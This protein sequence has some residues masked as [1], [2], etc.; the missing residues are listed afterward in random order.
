MTQKRITSI[1]ILLCMLVSMFAMPTA[2]AATVDTADTSANAD[3]A[4]TSANADVAET[5]ANSYGLASSVQGGQ[6]LQ[7]WNWSYNNIKN[8]LDKIAD[9]GFTAIQ[10][11]PIQPIKETT[12]ESWNTINN[13]SWVVYQ[14]VAFNIE[15]N[16]MNAQGTK[17][18]FKSLCT[19]AHKYGIK[20][21]VDTIF[22]HMANDMSGNTIHPWIP[23]EIK[24][25]S[26]CWHDITKNTYNFDDRYEVTQYC[27]TGL[28]DLNTS[29]SIVQKHCINF[30]KEAIDAGADGFRFDAI[31]H[32]E[33]PDDYYTYASDFWPNVL[34]AA[35]S[36]AQST[37]NLT[38]YYYGELIGNP[39][40]GL[41]VNA[42]T[43]YMSVSDPGSS[44]SIRDGVCNGDASKAA[45]GGI[46]CGAVPSKTVQWTESHDNHKDNG[47]NMVS[48]HNI[49]KVWAIVGSKAEV[50]GM[51]LARPENMDTTMMGDAD[52]TSWTY[53]EVKAVNRFK[54]HFEGQS[55]YLS[56]YYNLAC[57]ER[58]NSG[59]IIVNTGGTYYNGMSAP[60]HTMMD[61]T[62]KDAITGNTF[63]VSGGMISGDIGNTGIAVVYNASNTGIFTPGKVTG[64]SLPGSFNDWDS[65]ANV[66]M[67]ET[68]ST[69]STTISLAKGTYTFKIRGGDVWFSNTGSI[70]DTTDWNGASNPWEMSST[71][72]ADCTLVA[73]GGRYK[74]TY[75]APNRKLDVKKLS[76]STT[77]SSSF[78]LK[79]DF[80]SWGTD[81]RMT[82]VDGANSVTTTV[83]LD[84]GTYGFK[85]NNN[86][87]GIW[88]GNWGTIVDTT[89]ATS[90]TGWEMDPS[91]DVSN[92]TLEATKS[93]KYTF[94][95]NL[96]TQML[97]VTNVST[98][99]ATFKDWDGTVLKTQSVNAGVAPTA[100][101]NPTRTGYTFTG[102]SPAV[103]A[104]TT[105][106]TFTA[107]YKINSYAVSV[108]SS[109]TAGG[110]TKASASTVNY[111]STVTLTA[112][113]NS[114]DNYSFT[115]WQISGSYTI[116]SGSL[117]STS[118]TIAPTSAITAVANYTQAATYTVSASASTGG[119][120][121][122]SHASV[123][124]GNSV[125]FSAT[126]SKGYSFSNWTVSGSYTAVS[127]STSSATFTI[128]PSGNITVKANFA[129]NQSTVKF[130]ASTGG[131]VTNT[132]AAII[133]YPN[134]RS[135]TATASTGY[136][137]SS[138]IISGGTLGTDY[139]IT[140]GSTS[141]TSIS[142]RPITSGKTIT[143]TASFTGI[144]ATVKF[145]A[146]TGGT[147]TNSG[148]NSVTYPSTK[149][150]VASVSTG[151]TFSGWT[152]S[153]GTQ[154]TDYKITAGGGTNTSITIQ[155]LTEGKTITATASF[156]LKSYIVTFL[157]YDGSVLSSQS[158]KHGSAATAPADPTRT[159]YVFTGWDT[160]F[161]NVTSAMTVTA[162][163]TDD[164]VFLLGD[165]NGW[166]T[167][168]GAM[169]T[170]SGNVVSK[171][172]TLDA[173]TYEFKLLHKD[174]W[175]GNDGTIPDTTDWNGASNPWDMY[176]NSGNCKLEATGGT[177]T[178]KYNKSTMKLEVVHTAP[179]YT[180]TFKNY[181]GVTLKTETVQRGND[182]TAP[183]NPTRTATAQ[184]TYTFTG[185][186][187]EFTNI[188]SDLIVTAQFSSKLRQYTVTFANYD[189]TTIKTQK[190]NYGSAATAPTTTPTRPATAQYT[191]TFKA[192]DKAFN[193]ITGDTTITATYNQTVNKYTV[194]FVNYDGSLLKS[195]SVAYGSAATAPTTTPTKPSD[196]QYSYTF[197]G[198]DKSFSNITGDLTVTAVYTSSGVSYTVTFKNWNGSVI[199]TQSVTYGGSAKAPAT[200]PT[201]ES[202]GQY[203]Y[204]F[205]G[206]DK[207]L[208]NIT[209]DTVITAQYTTSLVEYYVVFLDFYGDV[210]SEQMVPYGHD[211]VAPEDP[212]TIEE[213]GYIYV[214][215]GWDTDFTNIQSDTPVF[216]LYEEQE[217]VVTYTVT[218][219]N[220]DGTV[221]KR[222]TVEEG[223]SATAPGTPTRPS[224]AQYSYT[225]KA[226]DK[227]FS[228]VTSDLTVTA[229]YNQTLNK[230]EVTFK[231]YDGTVLKEQ[232]VEYGSAATAP[233]DPTRD[234]YIFSGWD[235]EFL[236]ITGNT[237]VTAQYKDATAYL[238]GDFNGWATDTAMTASAENVVSVTL[239]L[240]AGE[241]A[242]KILRA[243][244]WY[245]NYGVIED[246]TVTTSDVGWEMIDGADN[247]TL[248]TTGGKYTF[249]FNTLTRMLEVLH[250]PDSFTVTFVNYNGVTLDTQT[251]KRGE[252]ATAPADPTRAATAQ[253]TYTFK[254]WDTDFTN[255]QQNLTVK[256]LFS[257][258][259]NKYTVTFKNWDGT[260]LSTQQ[261][262]YGKSATAPA[263][264][265]RPADAQYTYTFKAWD[266]SFSSITGDTVVTA[267]YSQTVNKY[268]VK[269]VNYDGSVLKSESVAYGSAAT[270]P[271][272]PV[273]DGYD[274]TG[275]DKDF[276]EITGDLTVTAQFIDNRVYLMGDFNGWQ[277]NTVLTSAAGSVV[278]TTLELE[279]GEYAFKILY[280]DVWYSNTGV[281]P[282]TTDYNGTSNPWEMTSDTDNCTLN[283]TGGIY[284]F[285]FD[286]SANK[287]EVLFEKTTFTV[288]FV[289]YNGTVLSTQ[290]VNKGES[291][292]APA[293]P[294][295]L[296]T[297]QYTFT[298]AG[299]DKAFT[300]IQ[301]DTTITATYTQTVNKYTVTF[302]N[303]DGSVLSTQT[304][305]YGKGATAP[306]EP[307]RSGFVF[308]GWDKDF[309]EIT[310]NL[311]VTAQFA[312]DK[313][314]LLGDFNDW[315]RNTIL[316][317]VE[318]DVVS[319]T[320]ALEEGDYLFK[321]LHR[322]VWYGNG[323]TIADTTDY[324]G[325]SN[326]WE[327][328]SDADNCTLSATGGIYT[329]K[330]N[331][332]TH[333]LEVLFESNGYTVTF[334]NWD[335]TV[336]S[337]QVVK[338]GKS[339]TAPADPARESTAE[340]TY[341]FA[342][343]DT[344]FTNVQDNMTVTAT[345]TQAARKY[346]V[347]YVNYD[348]KTFYTEQVEYGKAA[349]GPASMPTRP[350]DNGKVYTFYGWDKDLDNITA[351]VKT[352]ALYTSAPVYYTVTFV[353][354]DGAVLKEES[355]QH[356]GSATAPEA[357]AVPAGYK[358]VWNPADF[359]YITSNLTV[360]FELIDDNVYFIGDMTNWG[361][362][363]MA[364]TSENADIYSTKFTLDE[365]IYEFK[366]QYP[367][368][369]WL[370]NN[371][372]V[373][374]STNGWWATSEADGN[375]TLQAT[376][377]DY[378]FRFNKQTKQMRVLYTAPKYT[379]TFVDFDGTVLSTQQVERG[380]AATA[381]ADPYR[382]ADA[383]YT[384]TF[385]GW[386][387]D[388]S[389]IKEDTT[390]TA[391]YTR[392]L[393]SYTVTFVDWD[394]KILDTQ[395][396]E[397][398][399]A[400][401]EPE[402]PTRE[403]DA[404][405]SY[406]FAGWSTDDYKNV[407][408]NLTVV[409]T[410]TKVPN[411]FTVLFLD[412]DGEVISEQTVNYGEDAQAPQAPLVDGYIFTG[413]D[414][415]YT[416]IESDTVIFAVY[417][418]LVVYLPGD[419]NGWDTST[420]VTEFKDG[421]VTKTMELEAGT[422]TFKV[423]LN[424][425]WLG[426]WGVIEDTT[427]KTSEI[428]WEMTAD[429]D[430]CTLEATGGTYTFNFNPTTRM[431]EILFKA[432]SFTVVFSDY[433]G[434]ILK[435][436]T[437]TR[438]E[439]ATAPQDPVREGYDFRGWSKDFTNITED[440]VVVAV[441]E[442]IV[443]EYTV[444][445]VNYDGTVL[446]TEVVQRGS[447]AE[448]PTAPSRPADAQYTYE[449]KGWDK[450]FENVTGN[451]TVTA[452]YTATANK[453]TVT[454]KGYDGAV[455]STQQVEY[456]LAAEAPQAPEVEGYVFTGWDAKFDKI[457][458]NITVTAQYAEDVV[459]LL[460]SFNGWATDTK[461]TET[462]TENVVSATVELQE[463]TYSFKLL[464]V[465]TWYG[466]EGTIEDTTL[467]TSEVGWEMVADAVDCT[468]KATGGTYVFTFNRE[469]RML[470][471]VYIA[472]EY[473]VKFVDYNGT[474]LKE[475]VVKKGQS[476]T[477]PDDPT[478]EGYVF[479]GWNKSYTN[480]QADTVITAT[481]LMEKVT[482]TVTFVD[483]DGTV[484]DTQIVT[485][486]EAAKA[487]EVPEREGY[488]F[489]GWDK[490]FS[491]IT[492]NLT[493]TAL[494]EDIRV[495]LVGSFNE[496]QT[497]T[498]FA[499]TE[500][501]DVVTLEMPLKAGTYEFK[502]L[503]K[504]VWYTNTGVIA[505]T[506]DYEGAS[507]PWDMTDD[508]S[509]GNC[510]LEA[511][512]G[513]YTFTFNTSTNK[514]EVTYTAVEYT[515]TF[516][517]A[518]GTELSAQ[519]VK[520]GAAAQAPEAPAV[521]GF[522]FSKW[523][524]DFSSVESDM[525]VTA[526]YVE[527][528]TEFTVTFVDYDGN[529]LSSQK[530]A[531]GKSATAPA[532]PAR[533]G[534]IFTGWDKDFSKITSD[535]TV[536]AQYK[537]NTVYL[538][539]SFNEWAEGTALSNTEVADVTSTELTLPKGTYYFKLLNQDVWY[540]NE[541]IIEDTTLKT[542]E[543]GWEMS[544]DLADCTLEASGGKYTFK[545][546]QATKMLEITYAPVEFTVI[547]TDMEGEVLSEQKVC[548]GADATAPQAP[549]V[550]GYIFSGWDTD[551]TNIESDTVV[552]PIYL[553]D[554]SKF[555]V[556]FVDF[557]GTV[558]STQ[559]VEYGSAATAPQDPTRTGYIFTGWDKDFANITSDTTVVAQYKDNQ[560][561]LVGSFNEWA[562]DISLTRESDTSV[563]STKVIILPGTYYFKLLQ[564]DVWYT[565][566]STVIDTT[567]VISSE[568]I[569]LRS[570]D[571]LGDTILNAT[572]GTYTFK[573]DTLTNKLV[574]LYSEEIET[575]TV[576]FV[577]FDGTVLSEQT[578][579][580]GA[581][582]EAPQ[583]PTRESDVQYT[584][585]F[586]AWDK[587]FSKVMEDMTVTAVYEQVLNTYKVTFVDADGTVLSEQMVEYGKG[588]IA[589][590]VSSSDGKQFTGWD[591]AY[592]NITGDLTVTAVYSSGIA[593]NITL[594][595]TFNGWDSSATPFYVTEDSD[596]VTLRLDFE[597]GEYKFKVVENGGSWYGNWGTITDTTAGA[598]GGWEMDGSAGDCT[599]IASGGTYIFNY[600]ISTHKLEVLT[601]GD[602][603]TVTFVDHDGTV[604]KTQT[605]LPGEAAQAPEVQSRPG[606]TFTG[607]STDFSSVYA[608]L[609]VTATYI[610]IENAI[611]VTFVDPDGNVIARDYVS[612]GSAAKAPIPPVK[613][614]YI[615]NKWDKSFSNVTSE[616][617]VTAL[618]T[619]GTA[620]SVSLAGE[621]NGWNPSA[622]VML[623]T[624]N[625]NKVSI[626]MNLSEG[627]YKFKVVSDG[628][629]Y[630]NWGTIADTTITTSATGW[631][632]DPSA[633]D[634][635]FI[636]G[637]GTYIFTYTIST[638]TLEVMYVG[639]EYK[640][641][642]V[643]WDGTVLKTEIVQPGG[644][645]T[646]PSGTFTRPA[647]H[648]Y[649]YVYAGWDQNFTNVQAP[650]RVNAVY[651][652]TPKTFTVKFVNWNGALLKTEYV[653]YGYP[654]TPPADPTRAGYLFTGW[655]G[656]V[657]YVSGNMTYTAQFMENGVY[658]MGDFNG[659]NGTPL[660]HV[661]G[662]IYQGSVTL[663]AGQYKFKV[664][665]G[666][667]WYGNNG[668]IDDTTD[669]T[670]DV[671]WEMTWDAGDCTLNASG[672]TYTFRFNT[673][674]RMLQVFYVAPTYTVTFK[675]YNG[676]TLKTQYVKRG[677][678]AYAPAAPSRAGYIF[679]GW[680]QDFSWISANMVITAQYALNTVNVMG[681]FNSWSGT[682]MTPQGGN[683][684]TA[685]IQLSAG[686]Y[687]F[688]IKHADTWYGN[689]GTID[690]STVATSAVGW[691]MVWDAGD[692]TL[693]ATGGLYTFRFNTDTRML[694]IFFEGPKSTVTFLDWDGS[695][696]STQLVEYGKAAVAPADPVREGYTF[697][698]WS[699]DFSFITGNTTIMAQYGDTAVYLRGTFNNW[700]LSS[701]MRG[702]TEPNVYTFVMDLA[703]GTY[704]FKVFTSDIWYGNYGT[705]E[706]ST[707]HTS[708]T[709]WEMDGTAGD[710]TLNAQGGTYLFRFNTE[711]RMLEILRA[712]EEVTVTFVDW[713]GTVL[714]AQTIKFGTA[715]TAPEVPAREGYTLIGWDAAFDYVIENITVNALYVKSVV[716]NGSFTDEAG[717]EMA[718]VEGSTTVFGTTVELTEGKHTFVINYGT[719]P[720][721]LDS[722]FMDSTT[723][724]TLTTEG[725]ECT[726]IATGGLYKFLFDTATN[727]LVVE[728]L[729]QEPTDPPA[730][731]DEID[732]DAPATG[733]EVDPDQPGGDV[734]TPDEAPVHSV[735]FN[736]SE[737]FTIVT[738]SD[739]T[740]IEDGA[741]LSFTVVVQEGYKLVA[742]VHNMTILSAVDG[743]YTIENI[744]SDTPIIV[745]VEKD[746]T[747]SAL[748]EFTVTFTDKD[749]NVLK[750]ENVQYG[751]AATAP[752]AP[753]V[754]GY[755]FKGWNTKFDYVTMDI[756]V[757]ATYK[758][759][760]APVAPSTTGIIKIE[761]AGGGTGFMISVDGAAARPQ[762]ASYLNTKAPKGAVVTVTANEVAGATFIGWMNP[763][764]GVILTTDYAYTFISSG[765]DF[766]RAMYVVEVEGV[767]MVTFKNDK[768]NRVL[769]AQYY[770]ESDEIVFPEA[771]TQVG[772][773]FAGWNMTE[774]EIKAAIAAGKDVTV[775]ATWTKAVVPVQVTVN[776]G[777]GTGTYPANN[778][779][780][781]KAN[782]PEAGQKFAYWVDGD[783]NVKSYN[784][785]YSFFP[786]G[787]VE[788]TAVFVAE[789][790]EIE[791]Q[792]LVS[793]DSIDYEAQA[794]ANKAVFT[795][796]WYCPEGYT[797]VKAGLVA[798]NKDNFNEATFVAG[799]TD[800][801]VYDRS[802]NSANN[803]SVNTYTW[804]KSSVMSGQTWVARAYVQFRDANGQVQT[805]YSDIVEATKE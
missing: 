506:T 349:A 337:T 73:S 705:I 599:F 474:L 320:L 217:V 709:G 572:G 106:T 125:T 405:Y 315:Q 515:V 13:S 25:N 533:I 781:V 86:D 504:G 367:K 116:S 692:C 613:Q 372:T 175:L 295:R 779:V 563:F 663:I 20:I 748:P 575:F 690:N 90:A 516:V 112:T 774:A 309:S 667:D 413:W 15:T 310:G 169:S 505:D 682:P 547:F 465:D 749:G 451:L 527:D 155:P 96:N 481:Y 609:T 721:A 39:G 88:Y 729:E 469:T 397:Y 249:N 489:I 638:N 501:T 438:G 251:V 81:N 329:F 509:A 472:P 477:A 345:Y 553:D 179:S 798:V 683:V 338:E 620:S 495:Y 431:L 759:I 241:Y 336:L 404:H 792:I 418:E 141:S 129:G 574:I 341:T 363:A 429:A 493:V 789:D 322:D 31:K 796:S 233:A 522:L 390:I 468:L 269:F 745:V 59:M 488:A 445:F 109:P 647:D 283:A 661:S 302:V 172:Y 473:T 350:T 206:W 288:T 231:D 802:P 513:N 243:D 769:D 664:K 436:E 153:G 803:I 597:A 152:V 675:D 555:T 718:Q 530:V 607:W 727:I 757:K 585:T 656:D 614:G 157:D 69:A 202:D 50:C 258:T 532:D 421:I 47:T 195:E 744:T 259:L 680:D 546:N 114:S 126:S 246:T 163:Y 226:W 149:T 678:P 619:K 74:F 641:T 386:D 665:Q 399:F 679:T 255:V 219:V 800:S 549:V 551:F 550:D 187:K 275:W 200:T 261:I 568:G 381:P 525:T 648:G 328:T 51:Y 536:T 646:A 332:S 134:S 482:Y 440:I 660:K 5:A 41:S 433:D 37:R 335:G 519:T 161:S 290:T 165:F 743:V 736:Q 670:S 449:F 171:T 300:S 581:G 697:S 146:G 712:S 456:G 762:G 396:V 98:I 640:V 376:G 726:I 232:T 360:R 361:V 725:K 252:S 772:F 598:D 46:S 577:D 486:G 674:T 370:G 391:E 205:S 144:T 130:A 198:W 167:T 188:Q 424:D 655:D 548:L 352:T 419:F 229:T 385:S 534:Y 508:P 119:T 401:T 408:G 752:E 162:Q 630:G 254:G 722:T 669:Y 600:T 99:T 463:G 30:M 462:D 688:K 633:G 182:A 485:T 369:T 487:P 537:D 578:V 289:D 720:Y 621:F 453:Y 301:A 362:N 741:S 454:F 143:A 763:V 784:A 594:A 542:S 636:A 71:V 268:T 503:Y 484:L 507:N 673:A 108:S 40:G 197:S 158:V 368:D 339:A 8:N 75:D 353:S 107:Q 45:S 24:D 414:G 213:D 622:S 573:F 235:K 652:A 693:N 764:S 628:N 264:P 626:Q 110:T 723:G 541:G 393:V 657:N 145:S 60:V 240:S 432:P 373:E 490:D 616:M 406:V 707:I 794:A 441:Y 321:L 351:D 475:E 327:M 224:D 181:N 304:V 685:S 500:A 379:V 766:F 173:G 160:D 617:T 719:E 118:I 703:A 579:Y 331:A 557:D 714:S 589:P 447:A 230:Y 222:Q 383:Q 265:T 382:G 70:S 359:S 627:T 775:L 686:S 203:N 32:I 479:T 115:N 739:L 354:Y 632:M 346:T 82:Y 392:G 649:T 180:V 178:F 586:K 303:Y 457:T 147:V 528:N 425:Q 308:T 348:G 330:Y 340:Y 793:L 691:E 520:Y 760:V 365:G 124:Q 65:T 225:F 92:C 384:Y 625:S 562:T 22:N 120:A 603:F 49:N 785:E 286:T 312:D 788:L 287:L 442:E 584:Y 526:V 29:N 407:T 758:K 218:F 282:D 395:T 583:A 342:G 605:V 496:W 471:V 556:T 242:F 278:S 402:S 444:T 777:T 62:Y 554:E 77:G 127:G 43:K 101:S 277:T 491:S 33:T 702:T 19:E 786:S 684:Y 543:I 227:S 140:S 164:T 123:V 191:Y 590:E 631:E 389:Y 710:C 9:Q 737:N 689:N 799:T 247:C 478:R 245:G 494:Y 44:D 297:V 79:G 14:P 531:Y 681:D 111:G 569:E 223:K 103:G 121:S 687:K 280:K 629:W 122:A 236:N 787:D 566:A 256:A 148:S 435:K 190:V 387:K 480:I 102:W 262:E 560:I 662:T 595:G 676:T 208:N 740:A 374:D 716:L 700:D 724:M 292:K 7:C 644:S 437:V 455:L 214:F 400:A 430:N 771:P 317:T 650:L 671:G 458:E 797:F 378:E 307:T 67:A 434:T 16:Y 56:S 314:Y 571:M 78:Y 540:G 58:G 699:A 174:V 375:I 156:T 773:D 602:E 782:T 189:G 452:T 199:A 294:T 311:T 234:G 558:L 296:S 285:R 21:I 545:F 608:N 412:M 423:L 239:N 319:T 244:V 299:W 596:K 306:A 291:A 730:T 184:Y 273:R 756:T 415:D 85:L 658:V 523:D 388:F 611:V 518:D 133:T 48:E 708:E 677:N 42:Y 728:K 11:S 642:F 137:F 279:A 510:T 618:Y 668:W 10:T 168:I 639:T 36:Y 228:K 588:A 113:P 539:G 791:Y 183:A 27:L 529:I 492:Y 461:M 57:I 66:F 544:P 154:N 426:N 3:I 347:T 355:V 696:I 91:S 105:D 344:D 1:V 95:F 464:S 466:N 704:T 711:T 192:W 138:W 804:T 267:T 12:S 18:E 497:G 747:V 498:F 776:G 68:A 201:R 634:C 142:I 751:S 610:N 742:V 257:E 701:P 592:N 305:E 204:T 333:R 270:A 734:T 186:D 151:Y 567:D 483:F 34:N 470:E 371:T 446:K 272:A 318:G 194:K 176:E 715:A 139:E 377:G 448:A 159:G 564:N 83:T 439:A 403:G 26:A 732:P 780:T 570:D 713:D 284:T 753:E 196:A 521:E 253:Y 132:S 364:Q 6:I 263:N 606:Y 84:P 334:V 601:V 591:K 410:Y 128:K 580:V 366:F 409:A 215:T 443:S 237:T 559:Q 266:K 136:K 17:A 177:Y 651:T 416:N 467:A 517:G 761:V 624:G 220:Y 170:S 538:Y 316:A 427:L 459:Y 790:A 63:T 326:P 193:Y 357:P 207:S 623:S 735:I 150:S 54:N 28:P 100:P 672:S 358:G 460:G 767:Q 637:G 801:N 653:K 582:A 398:G 298:F 514:L 587:D 805:V 2:G 94:T 770:A 733:D 324:E 422:Y 166:D 394:N 76:S 694:E 89:T 561:Y 717:S 87:T 209:Q 61:G 524:K 604:L 552:N 420:P 4:D 93:G 593:S 274:F 35:T 417:E 313:V 53:P 211:A 612:K 746:E 659:W 512:G 654:A 131:S 185:W 754:E 666:N 104:I 635:T 499:D 576:T 795:Y 293:D 565:S 615:F 343:W 221:L 23:S 731:D 695:V 271:A 323:G 248:K 135:S 216:A 502:L 476:A 325:A 276:S 535:L 643:D 55:E 72:S 80:N 238:L 52:W 212:P 260:V 97:V 783:G 698:G 750:T 768:A 411:K 450:S 428:G 738:D 38:P 250:T 706:D 645:A 356:G 380:K 64:Y 210:I 765:N 755:E 281:I 117:T 511:S 778:Q